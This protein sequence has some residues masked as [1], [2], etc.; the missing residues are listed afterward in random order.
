MTNLLACFAFLACLFVGSHLA[1]NACL[2]DS[3]LLVGW[4]V[5]PALPACLLAYLASY[6]FLLAAC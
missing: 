2:L 1:S 3:R 6:A 4:L 5:L